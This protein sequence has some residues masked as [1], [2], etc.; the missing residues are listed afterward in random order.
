MQSPKSLP[1]RT[2]CVKTENDPCV[3]CCVPTAAAHSVPAACHRRPR[4]WWD[5]S[6]WGVDARGIDQLSYILQPF[7]VKLHIFF[8]PP[9]V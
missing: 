5:I 2:V 1:P 8:L 6:A 7:L 3:S 9:V 4:V